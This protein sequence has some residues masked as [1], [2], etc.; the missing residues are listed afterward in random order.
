MVNFTDVPPAIAALPK[1]DRG[2]P[3]PWFVAWV[4]GKPE[5]RCA[6]GRRHSIAIRQKRCWVCGEVLSE[7]GHAFVVGPMCALNRT[8]AEPPCHVECAEFSAKFCPFLSKPKAKR[9]EGNMPEE[10]A[11]PAGNAIMRNPGVTCLWFCRGYSLFNDG[12]G[13]MLIRLP[14]P[15]QVRWYAEG[16]KARRAEI[17]ESIETGLQFLKELAE[18]QGPEALKEL[19]RVKR[20]GMR[21]V[22]AA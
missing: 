3:V 7:K 4:N 6:D 8:T 19:E 17:V 20:V 10:A 11:E 12:R 21:F 15:S 14:N 2:Y 9:R 18:Q 22:P 16:R 1:D 13:G 5:F